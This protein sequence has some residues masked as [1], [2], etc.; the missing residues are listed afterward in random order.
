[1]GRAAGGYGGGDRP[2]ELTGAHV[3]LIL[4]DWMSSQKVSDAA[5][6]AV[7]SMVSALL[8]EDAE[9]PSFYSV[10]QRLRKY[11]DQAVRRIEICPNDCIAYYNTEHL[12][13]AH[14]QRHVHRSRCPVCAT[15]RYVTDPKTG[16]TLPAKSMYHFPL[17]PF[18]RALHDRPELAKHLWHDCGDNPEGHVTR[19]RGFRQK[20][21]KTPHM[22]V[23]NRNLALIGTTDGV[24]FFDD[25][26][27]GCWPFF[28]RFALN[29]TNLLILVHNVD[30]L[31]YFCRHYVDLASIDVMHIS[32]STI[33][34]LLLGAFFSPT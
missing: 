20:V 30:I 31:I 13:G 19:S 32:L 22:S 3:T 28:F 15:P 10:K 9:M 17:A 18:V 11:E 5:A 21:T 2:G 26:I 4:L 24:P 7:W 27:R 6:R 25:Q 12:T 34:F 14:A 23:D 29:H 16:R 1:M 8:P 33:M